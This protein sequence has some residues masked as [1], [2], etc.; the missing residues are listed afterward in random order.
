MGYKRYV[1]GMAYLDE[2]AQENPERVASDWYSFCCLVPLPTTI[3]SGRLVVSIG[4]AC[5]ICPIAQAHFASGAVCSGDGRYVPAGKASPSPP[6]VEFA[7]EGGGRSA[8]TRM[9]MRHR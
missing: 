8:E 6:V 5:Q 9:R 3:G 2:P 1:R 7:V 4:V